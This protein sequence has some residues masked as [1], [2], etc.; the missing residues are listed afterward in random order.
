MTTKEREVSVPSRGLSYLKVE[1]P[2]TIHTYAA[3]SVPSRGLS[4]LKGK[5]GKGKK[6]YYKFPSPH[7]DSLI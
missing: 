4:Y 3:V 2:E 1:E 6:Y 5:R 7:G